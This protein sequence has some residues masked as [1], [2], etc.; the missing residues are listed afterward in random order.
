MSGGN[1]ALKRRIYELE[2]ENKLLREGKHS[3]K[4]TPPAPK[5]GFLRTE[6][7][8]GPDEGEEA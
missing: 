1:E 6:V 7:I 3:P 5:R 2:A 8:K 4:E